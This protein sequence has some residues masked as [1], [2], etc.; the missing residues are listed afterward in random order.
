MPAL[1]ESTYRPYDQLDSDDAAAEFPALTMRL[2]R[3]LR[4]TNRIRYYKIGG[5]A[6]YRWIDLYE[7]V[8]SCVVGGGRR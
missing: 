6:Y 1:P 8:E 4:Q 5:K 3:T 7:F 2:L